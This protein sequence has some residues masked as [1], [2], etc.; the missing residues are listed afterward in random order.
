MNLPPMLLRCR[1][2]THQHPGKQA[3]RRGRNLSKGQ[4]R[5]A[6]RVGRGDESR[7]LEFLSQFIY[8]ASSM[9]SPK[10]GMRNFINNMDSINKDNSERVL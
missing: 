10:P 3:K 4:S 6:G 2:R 9:S 5:Q 1:V 8:W 7:G